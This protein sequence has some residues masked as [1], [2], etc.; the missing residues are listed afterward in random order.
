[1][2]YAMHAP[3]GRMQAAAAEVRR[4]RALLALSLLAVGIFG[5]S[6]VGGRWV[7]CVDKGNSWQSPCPC[8]FCRQ[9]SR[10]ARGRG[11]AAA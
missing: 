4:A 9:S 5:C 3:H 8:A 1:M 7:A 6:V 2:L 10:P 11:V